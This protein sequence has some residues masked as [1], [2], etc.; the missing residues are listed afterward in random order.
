VDNL[1]VTAARERVAFSVSRRAGTLR[2]ASRVT[3]HYFP[4]DALPG[5]GR[6]DGMPRCANARIL[7]KITVTFLEAMST[8]CGNPSRNSTEKLNIN[9]SWAN[10]GHPRMLA[11]EINNFAQVIRGGLVVVI[12]ENN[13]LTSS[14]TYAAQSRKR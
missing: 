7:L 13:D 12:E 2:Y 5:A 11:E 10:Y 9:V 6:K 3:L 8:G 14:F 4:P 1:A